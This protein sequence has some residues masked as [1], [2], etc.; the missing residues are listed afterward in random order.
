MP[1]PDDPA[2]RWS[3]PDQWHVTLRF[4][5]S[6]DDVASVRDALRSVEWSS[7][8]VDVGPATYRAVT[9]LD[10]STDD[11]DRAAEVF[12]SVLAS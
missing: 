12:A 5:G 8:Q 11:I 3:T 4:L 10:V 7:A 1:R 6:V 2:V 9:H